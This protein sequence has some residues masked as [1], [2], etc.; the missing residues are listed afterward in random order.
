MPYTRLR[1]FLGLVEFFRL[2]TTILLTV[3]LSAQNTAPGPVLSTGYRVPDPV[4]VAPGQIVTLFLYAQKPLPDF[5]VIAQN[6]PLPFTLGGFSV[7]LVQTFSAP[8]AVPLLA[9]FPVDNCYGLYPLACGSMTAITVQIPRE[10]TPNIPR[11]GRPSNFAILQVSVNGNPGD[12]IPLSAVTDQIH[13]LN[14]CDAAPAPPID[15]SAG[16]Q[17]VVKHWDGSLVSLTNPGIPGE[18]LTLSAYGL[19]RSTNDPATGST[20]REP[21]PLN[22]V[23]IGFRFGPNRAPFRPGTRTGES[24]ATP[25]LL[26]GHAPGTTARDV[27]L[28]QIQFQVPAVPSGTPGCIGGAITSNLTVGITRGG[29]SFSGAALCVKVP[30]ANSE[31]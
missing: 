18:T 8:V 15:A 6:T 16:C 25:P 20:A 23:E 5:P 11:A 2:A 7:Q 1:G 31:P 9:V 4:A 13:V 29:N 19:G 10:L 24:P 22:D 27:G 28:Y 21:I 12:G 26:A 3:S 14:T 30:P 17:P